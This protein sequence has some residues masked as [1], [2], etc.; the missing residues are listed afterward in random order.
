[1]ARRQ[2]ELAVRRAKPSCAARHTRRCWPCANARG[3]RCVWPRA[4]ACAAVTG[5][6]PTGFA[7]GDLQAARRRRAGRRRAAALG[8]PRAEGWRGVGGAE[9]RHRA[10]QA[11]AACSFENHGELG[12]CEVCGAARAEE[13]RVEGPLPGG[14]GPPAD[15]WNRQAVRTQAGPSFS[16]A[17]QVM[18]RWMGPAGRR[19]HAVPAVR[20]GSET[21]YSRPR[22]SS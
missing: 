16:R 10:A 2:D 12:E 1:V 3:A 19:R 14:R 8:P 15:R 9:A 13:S 18:D 6:G 5:C 11:C 20:R 4:E 22:Q 7:G 21:G 17:I